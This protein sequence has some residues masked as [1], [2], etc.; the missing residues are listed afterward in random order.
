LYG[1]PIAVKDNIDM[2]G[3]ETSC[4]GSPVRAP[5]AADAAIVRLLE[6]HG[7]VVIGKTNL[8]EA[9]LGATGRNERFGRCINPRHDRLLCGGSSSGSAASVAAGHTLLGVGTDTLGSVRIP[10]AFCGIAGFKPSHGCLPTAGVAPLHPRFDTVGLLGASLADIA[11]VFSA[12]VHRAA[13]ADPVPLPDGVQQLACLGDAA[14]ASVQPAL[15]ADFRRCVAALCDAAEFKVAQMPAMD[16]A[17]LAR[18]ALWEV[19]HEFAVCGVAPAPGY[20]V[21]NPGSVLRGLLDRA[22]VRPAAALAAGRSELQRARARLDA[23]L[24]ATEAIFT[25]TCPIAAP[26][27]DEDLPHSVA[28]FVASANVA[29]LPAVCW[30]QPLPERRTLSLQ[31]IGRRGGD[32]ALL[33][34]ATRVQRVLDRRF[35]A[36][37]V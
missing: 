34:L 4:G 21:S 8:D 14:L 29:G 31:L 13:P 11:H 26:G 25:P 2:A 7:A 19:A 36:A 5:A 32:A 23:C 3:T 16:F 9:A 22:R 33:E 15:A 1:V 18:A 27:I 6:S 12:L 20:P 37:A 35:A 24:A 10:A 28:D 17:A 30:P